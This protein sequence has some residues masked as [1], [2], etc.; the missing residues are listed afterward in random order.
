VCVSSYY[1]SVPCMTISRSV[2]ASAVLVWFIVLM[3][4]DCCYSIAMSAHTTSCTVMVADV[5]H[6][7][8]SYGFIIDT[9]MVFIASVTWTIACT[10]SSI[11]LGTERTQ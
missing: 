7:G 3:Q 9:H 1:A 11:A 6:Y 8:S 5:D 10:G 4:L 2:I